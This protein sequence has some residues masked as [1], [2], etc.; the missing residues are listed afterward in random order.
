MH[1]PSEINMLNA[2][3]DIGE[4]MEQNIQKFIPRLMKTML[5]RLYF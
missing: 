1:D 5:L 4:S 3:Y 2:E